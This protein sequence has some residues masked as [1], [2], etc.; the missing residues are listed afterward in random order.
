MRGLSPK[1][2]KKSSPK[3]LQKVKVQ[4]VGVLVALEKHG[5]EAHDPWRIGFFIDNE[6]QWGANHEDLGRWT[7]RSPDDRTAI[8][9]RA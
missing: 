6:I 3:S 7:L 5:R 1:S 4:K 9:L 8:L 2:P